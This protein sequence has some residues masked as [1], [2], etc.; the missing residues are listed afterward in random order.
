MGVVQRQ[1]VASTIISYVGAAIGALNKL[2]LFTDFLTKEQ[3]GLA[4]VFLVIS[5]IYVQLAS[6]GTPNAILRFF[7]YFNNKAQHHHGFLAGLLVANLGGFLL[8]TLAFFLLKPSIISVWIGSSPLL[9]DYYDYL[10]PLAFAT[11]L[12]NFFE[13][14]LRSLFKTAVPTLFREVGQRL[15][16]TLSIVLYA[17]RW[18]DFEQFVGCYVGFRAATAVLPVI[19]VAYLGELKLRWQVDALWRK[20]YREVFRYSLASFMAYASSVTLLYVDAIML[21]GHDLGEAGI[22]TTVSFATTLM[23]IPWRALSKISGPLVAGH[24]KSM[25]LGAMQS[26]YQRT[27]LISMF[28]GM[29]CF[30]GLWVNRESFFQILGSGYEAGV[31]VLLILGLA[32]VFDMTTG[33]NGI[34]LSTSRKYIWDFYFQIALIG[35][36]ILLNFFLIRWYGMDGAATATL[37]SLV[38]FNSLRTWVVFGFYRLHPFQRRMWGLLALFVAVLIVDLYTPNV[39]NMVVDI[40]MRSL[41]VIG[42][43][44]GLTLL[45]KISPDINA[46]LAG[47][48]TK[49]QKIL[50]R[51]S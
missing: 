22:Y 10:L 2:I 11:L 46:Y 48:W 35:V 21:T 29:L 30:L 5:V 33:L 44:G 31:W 4:N 38:L 19:Y 13:S 15:G 6:L 8:I 37:I 32:R 18:I 12:F 24:W 25:D 41:A 26:L 43:F 42:V 50:L 36:G 16:D 3:V 28:A 20:H 14:Y 23:M 47:I 45:L 7:P 40:L 39:P 9:V 49:V 1:G 27:S 51:T 34:I 17:L